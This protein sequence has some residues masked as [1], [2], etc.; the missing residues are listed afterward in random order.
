MTEQDYHS[1]QSDLLI[2]RGCFYEKL[3]NASYNP[4]TRTVLVKTSGTSGGDSGDI[5]PMSL[6]VIEK[7]L[8]PK[9]EPEYFL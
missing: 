3:E 4:I 8:D 6:S 7:F 2:S 9:K 5:H 1:R